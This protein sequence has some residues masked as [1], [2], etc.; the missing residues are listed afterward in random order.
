MSRKVVRIVLSLA[1]FLVAPAADAA[2]PLRV[3]TYNI[4]GGGPV[5][6]TDASKAAL[7]EARRQHDIVTMLAEEL[8]LHE[9]DVV[10]LQEAHSAKFVKQLAE[11]M[12]MHF[13]HFPGGWKNKGWPEG[14]GGAILSRH[15]IVESQDCPL[16]GGGE[17][18]EGLFTRCFGR[19]LIDSGDEKIAIY[20]AHLLPAWKNT[21]HIRE[22]EIRAIHAA[23]A[24]DRKAGV[25]VIVMGDMNLRPDYP[26]YKLW[27]TGELIDTFTLKGKGSPLTSS[28]DNPKVRIDYVFVTKPLADRLVECRV[29]WTGRFMIDPEDDKSFALSDHVPVL[30]IFGPPSQ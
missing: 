24:A 10:A 22:G 21:T 8:S 6:P 19:V 26:E 13:A 12:E 18:P 15:P 3:I 14:I 9:P 30:A 23:T 11:A 5:T 7:R 17:R 25:P 4:H 1:V 29:L 16:A 20:A 27:A 28:S 2:E